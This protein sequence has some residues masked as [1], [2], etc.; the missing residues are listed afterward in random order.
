METQ[1]DIYVQLLLPTVNEGCRGSKGNKL[2]KVPGLTA[3][4]DRGTMFSCRSR[5]KILI[6]RN[7]VMGIP[8]FS[9]CIKIRFIAS[10][11]WG[12]GPV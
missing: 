12:E 4:S 1:N 6:S 8:S 3:I 5:F 11:G 7:A 9:L 10:T 2:L